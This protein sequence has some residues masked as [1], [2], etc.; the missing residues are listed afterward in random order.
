MKCSPAI[1][2]GPMNSADRTAIENM[3]NA[4]VTFWNVQ[5]GATIGD[6]SPDNRG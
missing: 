5:G 3:L 2:G 6:Y 4:G 1:V